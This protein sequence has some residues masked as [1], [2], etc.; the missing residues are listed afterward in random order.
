MK[1]NPQERLGAKS[2]ADLKAHPFFSGID[3]DNLSQMNPPASQGPATKMVWKEDIIRE[4]EERIALEK[5]K[6]REQWYEI[7]HL[8]PLLLTLFFFPASFFSFF[9]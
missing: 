8:L 2:Y 6:L 1:K 7:D 4:E 3:W 5:K 9:F